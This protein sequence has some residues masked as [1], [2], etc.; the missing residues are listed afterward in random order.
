MP[1]LYAYRKVID[2]VT[3]HMLRLPDAAQGEQS[4]QELATLADGR[5]VVVIFDGYLLPSDQP[6]AIAS[7]IE[8]LSLPLP[9][10][11]RAQIKAASAHVQ[12]IYERT[13]SL[14]RAKYSMSDEAKYA[15]IGVGVALGAYT[16]GPGEQDEMLT[17]GSHC[18]SA[19]Q[20]GRNERA[21]L[22]L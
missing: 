16:F 15:R 21:K 7:S 18:E 22:G 9:D 11:L 6:A 13:E 2:T 10:L 4:G 1:S 14:I 3:T 12:L 8:A 19:R 20:W 17:F 5:T